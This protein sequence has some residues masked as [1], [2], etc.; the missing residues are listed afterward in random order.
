MLFINFFINHF[1]TVFN[2]RLIYNWM[3]IFT[4][5]ARTWTTYGMA[6]KCTFSVTTIRA[7]SILLVAMWLR[8]LVWIAPQFSSILHWLDQYFY[9]RA[10]SEFVNTLFWYA[11]FWSTV[12][13]KQDKLTSEFCFAVAFI[14]G[15]IAH[16]L[17]VNWN[18]FS[19]ALPYST[20]L[21]YMRY[22][23]LWFLL[24]QCINI[25]ILVLKYRTINA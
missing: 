21:S 22:N 15:F 1:I 4:I 13:T 16:L 8:G 18:I 24:P 7:S 11:Y 10:K 5:I 2:L 17:E 6:K 19:C 12:E 9:Y 20:I 23:V 14:N 25:C 3:T